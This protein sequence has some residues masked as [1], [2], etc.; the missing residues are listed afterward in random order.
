MATQAGPNLHEN[1][2]ELHPIRTQKRSPYTHS[3]NKPYNKL[4]ISPTQFEKEKN[5]LE[6]EL[7]GMKP[8]SRSQSITQHYPV[9]SNKQR[10]QRTN[11]VYKIIYGNYCLLYGDKGGPDGLAHRGE[12]PRE[13]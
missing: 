7:F 8:C 5:L 9:H 13:V 1:I 6:T 10:L 3:K 4:S 12:T 11:G 2:K